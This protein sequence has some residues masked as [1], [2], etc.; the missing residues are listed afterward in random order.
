M[1]TEHWAPSGKQRALNSPALSRQLLQP[2]TVVPQSCCAG[3]S[4]KSF[5]GS[6]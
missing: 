5:K 2:P 1:D 3:G 4:C 6:S